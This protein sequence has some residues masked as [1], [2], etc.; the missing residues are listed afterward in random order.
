MFSNFY[1]LFQLMLWGENSAFEYGGDIS[2][3]GNTLNHKWLKKYGVTNGTSSEDWVDLDLSEKC[4]VPYQWPSERA[5]NNAGV[6]ALFMGHFF[7]WDPQ[8]TYQVSKNMV[9]LQQKSLK[10]DFI[11]ML[12]LMTV[13]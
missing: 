9:L 11:N 3:M 5:Q 7:H 8:I 10:Q 1:Y 13:F 4:L 2:L 6:R 12:I